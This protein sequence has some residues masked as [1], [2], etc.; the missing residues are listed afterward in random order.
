M[1]KKDDS[2]KL[3]ERLKRLRELKGVRQE[4]A[5]GCSVRWPCGPF[6]FSFPR[7]AKM[8]VFEHLRKSRYLLKPQYLVYIHPEVL[9]DPFVGTSDVVQKV[10]F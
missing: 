6:L 2:Y 3:P 7:L 10:Q 8:I 1:D 9:S 5:A 4:D